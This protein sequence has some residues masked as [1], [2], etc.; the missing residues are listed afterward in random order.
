MKW[1]GRLVTLLLVVGLVALA[2]VMFIMPPNDPDAFAL[3]REREA[4][5]QAYR[6]HKP[7]PGTMAN[8]GTLDVRLASAGFTLG[9]PIFMRVFK[10]TFELEVWMK[11]GDTYSLFATYPICYFSGQ[12][13]P[14]LR[15][16]DRQTPEGVYLV[17]AKQLNPASRW[18]RAFNLGFPNAYDRA[19]GRTGSYLM[20]HGGCSSIGCYAVTNPVADDL[21]RLAT[22]AFA[23]GQSSFQVQAFP[24]R[25]TADALAQRGTQ[26]NAPFWE[27]LKDISEAFEQSHRPPE[28]VVCDGR[29]RVANSPAAVGACRKL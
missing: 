23:A 6:L 28:V 25:M 13:G 9:Q 7:L 14:K 3:A 1:L 11:R 12:L 21:F 16:F 4:R 10:L 19:Q 26:A 29:Y 8:N 2:Y 5:L 15:S 24:F 17:A 22:A 18:H 27:D 20:V